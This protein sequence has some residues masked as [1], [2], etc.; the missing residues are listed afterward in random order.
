[1]FADGVPLIVA[2]PFPLSL[3]VSSWGIVPVSVIPGAGE[4]LVR[5]VKLNVAPTVV[6]AVAA[7]VK[8]GAWVTTRVKA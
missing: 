7:L 8:A 1:V 5:T 4:P 6:L 2:V 3:K